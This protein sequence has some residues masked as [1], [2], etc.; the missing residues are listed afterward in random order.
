MQILLDIFAKSLSAKWKRTLKAV[1]KRYTYMYTCIPV[2]D[3]YQ[4]SLMNPRY[5]IVL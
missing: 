2:F 5:G 4:L 3:K 1:A